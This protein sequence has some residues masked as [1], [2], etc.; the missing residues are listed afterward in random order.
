MSVVWNIL[1]YILYVMVTITSSI[2]IV[3]TA[4]SR[5][6]CWNLITSLADQKKLDIKILY[7]V[8]SNSSFSRFQIPP[9]KWI[10]IQHEQCFETFNEEGVKLKV[11]PILSPEREA[12]VQVAHIQQYTKNHLLKSNTPSCGKN[13]HCRWNSLFNFTYHTNFLTVTTLIQG[14]T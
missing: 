11:N 1:S 4:I 13:W 3:H 10:S 7:C 12:A 2:S 8:R 9:L 6:L 5:V 14:L